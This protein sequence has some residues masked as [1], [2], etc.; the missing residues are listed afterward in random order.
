MKSAVFDQ[1]VILERSPIWS[2]IFIWLIIGMTTS[3]VAWA[4]WA[5]V[6][7]A[8]PTTGKLEPQ[9]AVVEVKPPTGGVVREIHVEGGELVRKGQLLLTL[10]PTASVADVESL[11]KQRDAL[12]QENQF[13]IAALNGNTVGE[14]GSE[15]E[16]L[17]KLRANLISENQFLRAQLSGGTTAGN[18]GEFDLNQEQLLAASQQE[19]RSRVQAARLQ[20]EELQKQ[21]DQIN[22]Q[23]PTARGQLVVSRGQLESAQRQLETAKRQLPTAQNQVAI[24]TQ[25]LATAQAQL[26][27]ARRQLPKAQ[28]QLENARRQLPRAMQQLEVARRQ[29]PT[30][31]AQ[32][33]TAKKSRDVNQSIMDRIQPVVAEG[34]LSE[35][36]Q[37]RQAQEILRSEAEVSNREAELLSRQQQLAAQEAEII[38]RQNEISAREAEV[39]RSENEVSA[40]EAEVLRLRNEISAREAEVM[41]TENEIS[42][43]EGEVLRLQNEVLSRQG[44]IERLTNEKQRI[45][46]AIARSRE[47]LQNTQALS[48]KDILSKIA[49]NQKRIS[50]ING[51]LSRSK[52]EN[53]KRIAQIEGQLEKANLQLRYQEIKAPV[54]GYVFDL[55]PNAE[56]YVVVERMPEPLLKIVPNQELEASVYIQNKDV[57]MVLDALRKA[58]AEGEEG[59]PVEV[60][61]E[62]FPATEY[63]TVN[64]MLTGVGSDVLPPEQTRPYYAFPATIELDSEKFLLNNGLQVELQSGMAVQ[65]NIKIGKRSVLQ[66]FLSRMTNKARTIETVK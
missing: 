43:R 27:N 32:L 42:G 36:Q 13:Y 58:K 23:L 16:N 21:L 5:K 56:D 31:Q 6:D 41:R 19:Y 30:A 26:Q 63:G 55:K 1:P 10:D 25:Q 59:V 18:G 61:I 22:N 60:N 7:Q 51:Q 20:V 46:V 4:A 24:A 9:G 62:A 29:I 17:T 50:D 57:A 11:K 15:L 44:E 66:I 35:L 33:A 47:E 49:E 45:N 54:S 39:L 40:R 64:G 52:L 8:V 14:A 2:S 37:E 12:K 65:A 38:N 3:G 48:Q 28:A 34:A 53:D